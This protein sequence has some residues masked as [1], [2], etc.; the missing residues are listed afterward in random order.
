MHL[1][2]AQPS[3]QSLAKLCFGVAPLLA[4]IAC[5]TTV[6]SLGHNDMAQAEAGPRTLFPLTGPPSYSNALRDVLGHTDQEISDKINSVFNQLFHGDPSTQ[7]IFFPVGTD[8]ANIQDIYHSNEIRT[9]GIG[10]GMIITV[11]LDKQTEFDQLWRYAK[12]E[13]METSAPTRGYFKS[14]CDTSPDNTTSPSRCLDPFGLE[15]FVMALIFAHDRWGD[16]DSSD[17]GHVDYEADAW[18]LFDVMRNKESENGGIVG[19]VT[20]TFDKDTS[21]VFDE[22]NTA[23][24]NFTRPSAEM[25]AYYEMWAQATHDPFWSVAASSGRNYL[26]SVTNVNT[27]LMPIRAYFSGQPYPEWDVFGPESYRTQLNMVLDQIWIGSYPWNLTEADQ[28]IKF[29]ANIEPGYAMLY[30]LDGTVNDIAPSDPSIVAANGMTA[31]IATNSSRVNFLT[32]A[33]NLTT[34]T[35]QARYYAGLMDLLALLVLSGQYRVY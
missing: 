30:A 9:E 28:L 31:M 12:S 29:F 11:E 17:A 2:D 13:L 23:S 4:L 6:D 33:W 20:N 18:S 16:G 22:P 15:Q 26:H 27:G 7:A 8:E 21:L 10:Y 34:P 24:N 1:T 14:Y 5:G 35:G 19:D 25:P 32:A 3:R